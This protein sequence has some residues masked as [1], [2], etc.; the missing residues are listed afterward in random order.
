MSVLPCP[1]AGPGNRFWDGNGFTMTTGNGRDF[2][3]GINDTITTRN[4]EWGNSAGDPPVWDRLRLRRPSTIFSFT[5]VHDGAGFVG[6]NPPGRGVTFRHGPAKNL[7]NVLFF[8]GHVESWSETQASGQLID[9]W[10]DA[11][12]NPPWNETD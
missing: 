2:D 6:G 9:I 7:V 8:D 10:W 12:D 11:Y 4:D 5:E 1:D 3:Y